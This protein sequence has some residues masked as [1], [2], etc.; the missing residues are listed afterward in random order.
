M[1]ALVLAFGV[2]ILRDGLFHSDPHPGN[3]FATSHGPHP[4]IALLDYGQVGARL[5]PPPP[6]PLPCPPT[7]TALP[8]LPLMPKRTALKTGGLSCKAPQAAD[9]C[10]HQAPWHRWCCMG[11]IQAVC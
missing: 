2:M 11:C 7:A 4:R 3:I 10:V 5:I 9:T 8:P 6:L 1:S